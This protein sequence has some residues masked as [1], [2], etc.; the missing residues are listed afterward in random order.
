VGVVV[1]GGLEEAECAVAKALIVIG[2]ER[3]SDLDTLWYGW[4]GNAFGNAIT[5][6]LG[7]TLFAKGR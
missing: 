6:G 1:P 5:V 3:Q 4:I 7:G 2:E